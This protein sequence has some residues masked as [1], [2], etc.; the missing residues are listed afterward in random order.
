[1]PRLQ[2]V[3]SLS[4]LLQ[5]SCRFAGAGVQLPEHGKRALYSMFYMSWQ[6]SEH[7]RRRACLGE[8]LIGYLDEL[9]CAD[10]LVPEDLTSPQMPKQRSSHD[11]IHHLSELIRETC[12]SSN[13]NMER[14][15]RSRSK[16]HSR[17]AGHDAKVRS[18]RRS[19]SRSKRRSKR[20]S[21]RSSKTLRSASEARSRGASSSARVIQH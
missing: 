3:H 1:M 11:L 21:R 20:H 8:L 17:R 9:V 10:A 18:E 15:S 6:V 13:L 5:G 19:E 12:L 2:P 16:R 14:H 7:Q 4:S